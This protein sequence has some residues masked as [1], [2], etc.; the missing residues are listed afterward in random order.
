[1]RESF[2]Q[3]QKCCGIGQRAFQGDVLQ[4]GQTGQLQKQFTGV[5]V[6]D[7]EFF[8]SVGDG[9][10]ADGNGVGNGNIGILFHQRENR[11]VI[12]AQIRIHAGKVGQIGKCGEIFCRQCFHSQSLGGIIQK[13]VLERNRPQDFTSRQ[14]GCQHIILL[15]RDAG[16][17]QI[18][19]L[20]FGQLGQLFQFCDLFSG[21]IQFCGSTQILSAV[22]DK[23]GFMVNTK[24]F[25]L[26]GNI[27][28]VVNSQRGGNAADH[29]QYDDA[30]NQYTFFMIHR[31]QLPKYELI[32]ASIILDL[33]WKHKHF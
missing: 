2:L 20:Q 33:L 1:M 16:I 23:I 22:H 4:I 6:D 3:L 15:E 30:Y 27:A 19:L 31:T 18:Q 21:Q 32:S 28:H 9:N 10:F 17:A 24:P 29:H 8:F 11:I 7:G 26:C 14:R 12:P 13:S 25:G 5:G